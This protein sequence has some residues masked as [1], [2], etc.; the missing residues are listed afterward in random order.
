MLCNYSTFGIEHE[1]LEN[2]SFM[3]ESLKEKTLN[4]MLWSFLQKISTQSISFII[5]VILARILTPDDY[6]IV[7]LAGMLMILMG[8]FSDGGLGPAIVQKK[9]ADEKDF[10]TMFV[11]QL[12]FASV[13]YII[14]F[15][16]APYFASLFNT[17]DEKLLVDVIRVMALGMPLG[18]LAGVQNSVVTRRM[19]FKWYFISNSFSL[20][21]SAA[22]GLYLAYNGYGAWALIGQNF[23]SLITSTIVIFILLDWHPKFEF[24]YD[25]FLPLFTTGLKFMGTSLIGTVTAQIKGYALGMKYSSADLAYFNRGE[26]MPNLLCNNIDSTIQSVL[27]PALVSIQEDAAAVKRSLRRA[28]R[29]STYILFP[30]LFGLA[31]ISDKLVIIVFTEKWAPCIPFMQITCVSLAIGIMCNVNLQALKARGMIGIVLKLEFIKKP[32]MF[33]VLISTMLISP[34]AMAW[35]ILFFNIFVYFINSC[36][37][38]KNIEYSYKEQLWDVFPNTLL[39]LSMAIFVYVVGFF[40]S[41]KYVSVAVQIVA[42]A[43][44]YISLSVLFRNE[45]YSYTKKTVL[46]KIRKEKT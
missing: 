24:Y 21:T 31:A 18:A 46:D 39:A 22:V 15:F 26:G 34:I 12:L 1:I 40:I 32:I 25:R 43:L 38:K 29:I 14:V 35:G 10:N 23:T 9:D 16:V 7:A 27:F 17:K 42:G 44:Y 6:G 33:L 45:P 11:T 41:N 19:M 5:S 30:L 3:K 8:I 13:M 2:N 28:I 36:P 20:L 4:G 37:N